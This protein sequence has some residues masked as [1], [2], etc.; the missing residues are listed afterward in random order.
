[1]ARRFRVALPGWLLAGAV[2]DLFAR[3]E[4]DRLAG[5][6]SGPLCRKTIGRRAGFGSHSSCKLLEWRIPSRRS[7]KSRRPLSVGAKAAV[8]RLRQALSDPHSE[9]NAPTF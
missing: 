7:E 4:N 2:Q 3:R 9:V 1:M 5:L 8:A 6:H